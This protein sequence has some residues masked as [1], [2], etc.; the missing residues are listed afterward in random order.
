MPMTLPRTAARPLF[1]ALLIFLGGC[2][3]DPNALPPTCPK[4]T[5]LEG[6]SN[7]TRFLDGPGRD[8]TDVDFN[9]EIV[10]LN[11]SCQY[12][13]DSDTGAGVLSMDLQVEVKVDRGPANRDRIAK[14]DYFVSILDGTGK[15]VA[16]EIFPFKIEFYGKKMTSR[17]TD[18]PIT[19]TIPLAANQSGRD[20]SVFVGF[21]LTPNE[22]RYNRDKA[23]PGRS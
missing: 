6:T 9:G 15:I 2:A 20:Y 21:Q 12:D 23:R 13:T 16:K 3:A 19:M 8:L 14:F 4:A 18:A 22:V 17:D 7:L 11:G 10:H 1:A 5:I